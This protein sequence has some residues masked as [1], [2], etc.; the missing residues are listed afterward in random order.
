MKL[1]PNADRK[2]IPRHLLGQLIYDNTFMRFKFTTF[3]VTFVLIG[4]LT[5]GPLVLFQNKVTLYIVSSLVGLLV[6][7]NFRVLLTREEN[8]KYLTTLYLGFAGFVGA[9]A[10]FIT[11]LQIAKT[12]GVSSVIYY[13]VA[14]FFFLVSWY[15][16]I[17]IQS[18]NYKIEPPVTKKNKA[19][20]P[21][22]PWIFLGGPLGYVVVQFLLAGNQYFLQLFMTF[23]YQFLAIFFVYMGAKFL[24]QCWFMLQNRHLVKRLNN[25]R[26]N[27]KMAKGRTKNV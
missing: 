15:V 9:M 27:K 8:F 16:F 6:I 24:S 18:K 7:L 5:L 17:Y 11:S 3:F 12:A 4:L 2:D 21:V 1:N 14:A 20:L 26:K 19:S 13:I 23:M 22:G 10:Y 25:E